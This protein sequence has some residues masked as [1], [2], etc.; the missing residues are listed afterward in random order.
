MNGN[1]GRFFPRFWKFAPG[2][3]T[4]FCNMQY[5]PPRNDH[6]YEWTQ[7]VQ[8]KMRYYGISESLIK[9]ITRFPKRREEGIAPG[10]TAV[11][12]PYGRSPKGRQQPYAGEIWVMYVQIR[13]TK[14]KIIWAW[15][16]PGVSPIGAKIPIPDE[17]LQELNDMIK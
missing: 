16:Y 13:D 14:K 12:S 7:H 5:K 10:T 3:L 8:D 17:I 2:Q 6:K 4:G 1:A 9:R 15:R 11:M